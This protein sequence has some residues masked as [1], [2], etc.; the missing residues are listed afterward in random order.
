MT[1]AQIRELHDA[2]QPF[3]ISVDT[4]V[5]GYYIQIR[6]RSEDEVDHVFDVLTDFGYKER[7]AGIIQSLRAYS[8]H[9]EGAVM[10]LNFHTDS[11]NLIIS[12][13]GSKALHD[14]C[15]K[16]R[17]HT[18]WEP[19]SFQEFC[20][21][22]RKENTSAAIVEKIRLIELMEIFPTKPLCT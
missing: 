4:L 13:N 17:S 14:S 2:G 10:A 7:N 21:G 6:L 8:E 22:M 12:S 3:P 16:L 1:N 9:E 15:K 20:A 5:E 19:I 18:E 11:E